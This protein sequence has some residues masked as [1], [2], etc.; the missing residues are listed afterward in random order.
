MSDR[1]V[2]VVIVAFNNAADIVEAVPPLLQGAR[3]SKVVVI[4][5]GRDDAGASASDLGA[6][7]IADSSNP[8]F[9]AGQNRG[10]AVGD[11]RYVLL[12]N[13][14]ARLRSNALQEGV[15][16]LEEHPLVAAV[17]GVVTNSSTGRAERSQGIE[18]G[19]AHLWGRVLRARA[20]LRLGL[21][22][23]L[24]GKVRLFRD[25][26]VRVP[27]DPVPVESLAATA[28]LVRR[29]AFE[30][31]GGFDTRFF[32][33]GEDLDLC[34][35]LR[36]EGWDLHAL[37]LR[38]ADHR[39]GGSAKNSWER[40]LAWWS[41]TLIFAAKWWSAGRW[42]SGAAAGFVQAALLVLRRPSRRVETMRALI[43]E[44]LRMRR[45]AAATADKRPFG[46]RAQSQSGNAFGESGQGPR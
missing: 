33:Y 8:G 26:V 38:W 27:T 40:E 36:L 4:D 5:H 21:A 1:D 3:V 29:S 9:G 16:Y 10:V 2:D 7:A 42:C 11:S 46:S 6:T 17:Q 43:V 30:D 28:M 37:P 15:A 44:P 35:R 34:R 31:V 24:A 32:M 18:L 19:P 14:D 12:L 20:L 25:H 39:S 45:I 41:G 13:P 23:R 22:R